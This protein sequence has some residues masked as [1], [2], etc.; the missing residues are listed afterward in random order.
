MDR[1]RVKNSTSRILNRNWLF[2][3]EREL[4]RDAPKK[5]KAALEAAFFVVSTKSNPDGFG[6]SIPR[7]PRARCETVHLGE[8][9]QSRARV[10][11]AEAVG[12]ET[13]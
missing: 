11:A 8:A 13:V 4:P 7:W 10:R 12:A 5:E 6:F 9:T 2:G 1:D 3:G